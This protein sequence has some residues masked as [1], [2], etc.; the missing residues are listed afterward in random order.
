MWD[1]NVMFGIQY[2]V[3]VLSSTTLIVSKF[4]G[5]KIGPTLEFDTG[6]VK[7]INDV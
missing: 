6:S 5:M 3:C 4:L 2:C 1:F 7:H